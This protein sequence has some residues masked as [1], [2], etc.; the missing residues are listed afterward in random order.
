MM[1]AILLDFYYT[2]SSTEDALDV[3]DYVLLLLLTFIRT[4]GTHKQIL[5]T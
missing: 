1:D 5:H 3:A 4:Q 2:N